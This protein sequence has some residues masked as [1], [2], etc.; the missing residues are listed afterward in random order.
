M[1]LGRVRVAEDLIGDGIELPLRDALDSETQ[2]VIDQCL[3]DDFPIGLDAL[4][5]GPAAASRNR[6]MEGNEP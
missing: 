3:A 5:A 4:C 6:R 1:A 2:A